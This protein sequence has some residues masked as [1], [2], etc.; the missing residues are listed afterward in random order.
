ML[1]GWVICATLEACLS[2]HFTTPS[3]SGTQWVGPLLL[4]L[5]EG[6]SKEPNSG[7]YR[8]NK[9]PHSSPFWGRCGAMSH[10]DTNWI[11]SILLLTLYCVA[12]IRL[13]NGNGRSYFKTLNLWNHR[14][15]KIPKKRSRYNQLKR[16][17]RGILGNFRRRRLPYWLVRR[18]RTRPANRPPRLPE[19]PSRSRR[20]RARE[21]RRK[22]RARRTSRNYVQRF[23]D[24]CAAP[25]TPVHT[26]RAGVPEDTL[27]AFVQRLGPGGFDEDLLTFDLGTPSP[28]PQEELSAL[29]MRSVDYAERY[30]HVKINGYHDTPCIW[31]TGASSD[32]TPFKADFVSYEPVD[33]EVKGVAGKGKVAGVGRV[34]RRLTTRDGDTVYITTIAYHMPGAEVRL[35]SP[36][37]ALRTLGGAGHAFM[38]G[39]N[40]EW[41]LPDG[42]IVDIPVDRGT[43][44]PLLKN[45]E[46]SQEEKDQHIAREEK[47][48]MTA[49][50][51]GIGASGGPSGDDR[52]DYESFWSMQFNSNCTDKDNA[53]L[54]A[55]QK[56]LLMWHQRLCLNMRDIQQLMR[57]Q[58]IKDEDGTTVKVLPP[59]IPTKYKSTK[60]LKRENYPFSMAA[61]L[62]NAKARGTGVATSKPV[63]SKVGILSRDQYEPGDAIHT[64]QFVVRTPG[65]LLKGYGREASH[66]S[67]S[68][69]TIFQDAASN[70]VR[71]QPQVSL[72]AGETVVAK[73]S[74]EDWIW[75]LAGVLAKHY[76]SDNGVFVDDHFRS[77]C[78]SKEQTQSFS[79]VG[80][81][82]QNARAERTIQTISYWARMMMVHVSLH[83]PTDNADNIR[84]WAFAVTHAE[85]LYNHMPNRTLG[86]R[87]PMEVFT[88][89]RADH[90]ELLRTHVWGCPAFVL[91]PK[92]QDDKK[93][94]KFN[95]RARLG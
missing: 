7:V 52:P 89:R 3:H 50:H 30:A 61:K 14:K 55:P 72:G 31:D 24:F 54:T 49:A 17:T 37:S 87:S 42:R 95:R 73:S 22:Y 21:K 77:D 85:W 56:E 94:A 29:F 16:K 18:C 15:K 23:D 53:N 45:F 10:T 2:T 74:F 86:W 26:V 79:G 8:A 71:V 58:R 46:C 83:W 47:V 38:Q 78:V 32:L 12:V 70:L 60:N 80:A 92:L 35:M 84:L 64:D 6:A 41:A 28:T 75:S 5:Q 76:H 40:I 19:Q 36:Q 11:L 44:L 65:R 27:D 1:F 66:H 34:L 91:N 25:C 63:A 4:F 51:A 59:I 93:I 88:G 81:K 43:N 62:A 20:R 90:K 82:H 57:P 48:A 69:G 33:L 9:V 39:E 67:Y 13:C 68:G